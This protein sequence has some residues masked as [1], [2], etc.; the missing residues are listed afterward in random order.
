M[1]D[2]LNW[3]DVI[4]VSPSLTNV[5]SSSVVICMAT[6]VWSV[7]LVSAL[8]TVQRPG[9]GRAIDIDTSWSVAST[10]PEISNNLRATFA[11]AVMG[12]SRART[13][14]DT[15]RPGMSIDDMVPLRTLTKST[16]S[17]TNA[18]ADSHISTRDRNSHCVG[19]RCTDVRHRR[20]SVTRLPGTEALAR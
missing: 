9:P 15:S 8:T 5:V 10:A 7:R 11:T 6:Q 19:I 13:R 2:L 4:I 16:A 17:T 12:M 14:V 3:H 18:V 20:R 1:N